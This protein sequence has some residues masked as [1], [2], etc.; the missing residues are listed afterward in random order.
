[1]K[2]WI[3]IMLTLAFGAAPAFAQ[4]PA[5]LEPGEPIR[6]TYRIDT[7][8][9]SEAIE[10]TGAYAGLTPEHLRLTVGPTRASEHEVT[11]DR[12]MRLE[13]R[14]GSAARGAVKGAVYGGI[15]GAV[16]G[17][18]GTAVVCTDVGCGEDYASDYALVAL[19]VGGIGAGVGS[20]IGAVVG[21]ERWQE[22]RLYP[23]TGGAP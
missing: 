11:L 10:V 20:L 7:A 2:T 17:L 23:E 15:A 16:L 5:G 22:V 1:M 14:E 4:T 8:P 21:R 3:M 19:A 9:G 6:A 12:L 18:L 13:A